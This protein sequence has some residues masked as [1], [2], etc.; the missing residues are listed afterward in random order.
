MVPLREAREVLGKSATSDMAHSL[1]TVQIAEELRPCGRYRLHRGPNL[2]LARHCN[3]G[4][5]F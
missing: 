2:K 3:S 4:Q 5:N 1:P